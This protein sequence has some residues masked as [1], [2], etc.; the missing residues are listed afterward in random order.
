MSN[1]FVRPATI[2]DSMLIGELFIET[3]ENWFAGVFGSPD[4]FAEY[5]SATFGDNNFFS[6]NTVCIAEF[7]GKPVGFA[8]FF[9]KEIIPNI[10]SVF[11]SGVVGLPDE[12]DDALGAERDSV[13]IAQV[14]KCGYLCCMCVLEEFRNHGVGHFLLDY[15]L[16]EV[17]D[18]VL[19]T[20]Y[21]NEGAIRLY[22]SYGFDVKGFL[23]GLSESGEDIDSPTVVYMMRKDKK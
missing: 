15:V 23:I 20:S 21:D 16:N 5:I 14:D 7:D 2:D 8:S 12:F 10:V 9:G 19:Y 18:I 13:G 4:K 1:I 11:E 17:P 22:K 6:S 3:D